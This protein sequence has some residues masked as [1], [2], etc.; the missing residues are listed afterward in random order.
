MFCDLGLL[1]QRG[2]NENTNGLL[3]QYFSQGTDLSVRT[4]ECLDFV[5]MQLNRRPCKTLGYDTPAER[6]VVLLESTD[7]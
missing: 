5:A 7:I 4:V 1:W 6:M 2:I 3:W